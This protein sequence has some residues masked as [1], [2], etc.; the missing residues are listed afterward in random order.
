[1]PLIDALRLDLT[2]ADE[3]LKL[4]EARPAEVLARMAALG[5]R[6]RLLVELAYARRM[7]TRE[8]A[9]ILEQPAG[10]IHRRLNRICV[11]LRDPIVPALLAR[12]CALTPDYRQ[13]ALEY[14]AQGRLLNDIADDHHVSKNHIRE[15]VQFVRGWYRGIHLATRALREIT[16]DQTRMANE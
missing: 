12:D 15:V 1:M 16:N 7:S 13:I 5:K 9:R 4:P 3:R 11:R 2:F 10:T 14:F 6:D 8:I